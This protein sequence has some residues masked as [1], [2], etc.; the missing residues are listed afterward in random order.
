VVVPF[1]KELEFFSLSFHRGIPWYLDH[2]EG[3]DGGGTVGLDISPKYFWVDAVPSRMKSMN[4][5]IRV[6]LGVRDPVE[7][8][9]SLYVQ[10]SNQRFRMPSFQQFLE[11]FQVGRGHGTLTVRLKDGAILESLDRYRATFGGN[12]LLYSFDL[13]KEDPLLVIGA[14][15]RFL[16]LPEHFSE[17]N[18]ENVVI[19]AAGRRNNRVVSWALSR[20]FLIQGIRRVFPAGL[21]RRA[22]GAVDRAVGRRRYVSYEYPEEHESVAREVLGGQSAYVSR[23]L[24]GDPLQ[25]G[26]GSPFPVA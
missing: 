15:E 11:S 14:I 22:R 7:V 6:V 24:E 5:D 20:E 4:P 12:L 3:L 26:D 1:R 19:N 23:L 9:L 8:A 13:M 10:Q 21:V 16:G 17:A 18:F 25:L 2:F